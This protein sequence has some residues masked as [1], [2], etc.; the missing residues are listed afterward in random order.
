MRI[1]VMQGRLV[2]PEGGRFQSFPR[3]RWRDEFALAKE[4]DV[5]YIEWIVDSDLTNPIFSLEGRLEMMAL[6][7]RNQI[8]IPAICADWLMEHPLRDSFSLWKKKLYGLMC[9]AGEVGAKRIIVPFVDNSS[10]ATRE[11]KHLMIKALE[12]IALM[13]I[14]IHIETDLLP[15]RLARL[16]ARLPNIKANWDS[17]NSSGRGYVAGEEFAAY[18]HRIGSIHIKD[19]YRLP[20][21]SVET[22]PLGEGSADFDDV[23]KSIKSIGYDGDLTLQVARGVDGDEVNWIRKQADFVRERIT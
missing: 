20:D 19:R 16:L 4:A 9:A 7:F 3:L 17:G 10:I 2:P 21:G 1:G 12:W 18:G 15:D 5:D 8:S 23:F 13:D 6:A 14:E 22:R 11:D